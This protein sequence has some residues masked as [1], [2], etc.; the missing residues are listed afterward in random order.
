MIPL[1]PPKVIDE[2]AHEILENE[3]ADAGDRAQEQ[4]ENQNLPQETSQED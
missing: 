3:A 2:I 1:P 4:A